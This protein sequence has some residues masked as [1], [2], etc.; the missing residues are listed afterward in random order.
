[1]KTIGLIGGLSW[2][3][4]AQYYRIINQTTRQR[5]GGL[6]SASSLM[7]TF[8][9][10]E[11]EC[12]HRLG[13]WDKASEEI[14]KAAQRLEKGGADFIVICSVTTHQ[15]YDFVQPKI[16][17]P[18]FHIA[19]AVGRRICEQKIQ[20]VGL[21][22]TKPTMEEDFCKGRLKEKYALNVIVPKAED[23]VFINRVI[24]D[25]LCQGKIL[26]DSKAEY[27]RIIADLVAAGAQAII[28]GCTEI[29]L[30]INSNDS[31]VPVFDTT[32]IHAESSVELALSADYSNLHLKV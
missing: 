21:L 30:L 10:V 4:S 32:T 5:L 16:S 8:D 27:I 9:F 20:K 22:G 1:M 12:L 11:I 23:R 2:E 7:Y 19:D 13:Q 31:L 26:P 15:A 17:V 24:Y 25:E 18:I 3:S 6:H 28:L 29:M 14:L